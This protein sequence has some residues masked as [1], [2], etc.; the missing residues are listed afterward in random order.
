MGGCF[1]KQKYMQ[2]QT[3][4]SIPGFPFEYS[5]YFLNDIECCICLE[6]YCNTKYMHMLPCNHVF[7]LSCIKEWY[8]RNE[9]CPICGI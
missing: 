6:Q 4:T 2:V 8:N 5:I 9:S 7:H 1:R 3:I